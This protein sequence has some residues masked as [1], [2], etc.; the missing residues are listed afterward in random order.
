[1]KVKDIKGQKV[2]VFIE[3]KCFF[4]PTIYSPLSLFGRTRAYMCVYMYVSVC[5][6]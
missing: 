1:V 6:Y 5:I 2:S 4:S 3:D